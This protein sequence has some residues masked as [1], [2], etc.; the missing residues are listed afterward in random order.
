[1]VIDHSKIFNF[2]GRIE[3]IDMGRMAFNVIFIPDDIIANLPI[4]KY[5]KLRLDL[6]IEEV[7]LNLALHPHDGRKYIII[8][9]KL[10][11]Q[12]KLEFSERV[13][14][15]FSIADQ[16]YVYI[17]DSLKEEL[18][19]NKHFKKKWDA[20]TKGKQRTHAHRVAS[21]KQHVTQLKRIKEIK[22]LIK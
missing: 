14:V 22:K 13:D 11:R 17:P 1:M 6:V 18:D 16:D 12:E 8:S 2:I 5:P 20:L 9:N 19:M 7:P 10:I 4:K 15:Q 21:A 3:S